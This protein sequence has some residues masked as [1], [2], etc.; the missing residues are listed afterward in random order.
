MKVKQTEQTGGQGSYLVHHAVVDD[1]GLVEDLH[2]DSGARVR[3]IDGDTVLDAPLTRTSL[4]CDK[5]SSGAK[6]T[7]QRSGQANESRNGC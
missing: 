1:G 2:G 3:V 6:Q 4:Y 5:S 7:D